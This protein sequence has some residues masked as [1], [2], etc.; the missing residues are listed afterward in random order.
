MLN[1]LSFTDYK[2]LMMKKRD[3]VEHT[4]ELKSA[5]TNV[6]LSAEGDVL[7]DSDRY[8]QIG[9]DLRDLTSL[10][11]ILTTSLDIQ[12]SLILFTA[13][14]SIT[15]MPLADADRLIQWTSSLPAGK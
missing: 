11:R 6:R 5:F 1:P 9:C 8:L 3:M 13:E 15:Y 4:P 2:E 12:N 14:V 10:E 7:L